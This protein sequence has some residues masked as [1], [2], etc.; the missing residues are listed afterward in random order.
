MK[1]TTHSA[2]HKHNFFYSLGMLDY[3]CKQCGKRMGET[4][5]ASSERT[6]DPYVGTRRVQPKVGERD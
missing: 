6:Y 1:S 4:L 2:N 5:T 3:I